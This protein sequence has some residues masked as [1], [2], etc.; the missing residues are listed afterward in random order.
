MPTGPLKNTEQNRA[1]E[2]T[3]YARDRYTGLNRQYI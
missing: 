2:T 1:W 3:T